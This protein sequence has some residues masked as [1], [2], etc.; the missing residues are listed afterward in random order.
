MSSNA[1]NSLNSTNPNKSCKYNHTF[2]YVENPQCHLQ[3]QNKSEIADVSQVSATTFQ[4]TI[5]KLN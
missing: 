5:Q 1:Y 4:Q 2:N 3:P